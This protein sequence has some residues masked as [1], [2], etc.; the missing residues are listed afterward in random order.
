MKLSHLSSYWRIEVLLWGTVIPFGLEILLGDS[1]CHSGLEIVSC[2]IEKIGEITLILRFGSL[3]LRSLVADV[4]THLELEEKIK[5]LSH[6][7][8]PFE[9]CC[10]FQLLV[11]LFHCL[12]FRKCG[13][14]VRHQTGQLQFAYFCLVHDEFIC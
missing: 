5:G 10:Y 4:C 12:L 13:K 3:I 1:R 9:Y 6:P 2:G 14:F 7:E 8:L 11:C